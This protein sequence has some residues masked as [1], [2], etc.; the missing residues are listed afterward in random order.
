MWNLGIHARGEAAELA[1]LSGQRSLPWN[2]PVIDDFT[3]GFATSIKS[4]DLI[5]KSPSYIRSQMLAAAE[6]LDNF[7]PRNWGSAQ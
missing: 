1:V 3:G 5:G 2:Y 4:M 6:K 7:V